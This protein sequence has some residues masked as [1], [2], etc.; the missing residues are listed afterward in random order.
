MAVNMTGIT[1]I[2]YCI[3]R[4][5]GEA[6]DFYESHKELQ[7]VKRLSHSVFQ[8]VLHHELAIKRMEMKK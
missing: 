6:K 4:A 7:G 8:E 2:E 5:L 3:N 1:A